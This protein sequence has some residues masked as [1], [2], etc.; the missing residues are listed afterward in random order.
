MSKFSYNEIKNKSGQLIS[1][2]ELTGIE[3]KKEN[4]HI[5]R[6]EYEEIADPN[7]DDI[8][9]TYAEVMID[10]YRLRSVVN[11]YNVVKDQASS[12]IK[13]VTAQRDHSLPTQKITSNNNVAGM[14][15]EMIIGSTN[16]YQYVNFKYNFDGEDIENK[17]NYTDIPKLFQE[18]SD[19]GLISE[20]LACKVLSAISNNLIKNVN[21][22]KRVPLL[23]EGKKQAAYGSLLKE[24]VN[25]KGS[26]QNS[27]ITSV[28]QAFYDYNPL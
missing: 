24:D 11:G 4:T 23:E 21:F 10:A 1:K 20:E 7:D 6:S 2:L 13:Q 12:F 17:V 9:L 26:F 28:K 16:K 8:G 27:L 22:D 15:N 18:L 25:K 19:E 14:I 3:V 5:N